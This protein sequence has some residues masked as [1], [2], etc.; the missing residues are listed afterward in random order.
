MKLIVY[1]LWQKV[2]T[3]LPNLVTLKL[4]GT[5]FRCYLK[6]KWNGKILE[7]DTIATLHFVLFIHDQNM[8]I[9]NMIGIN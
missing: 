8:F 6:G 9:S 2:L 1:F 7:N 3:N 5:H 4:R